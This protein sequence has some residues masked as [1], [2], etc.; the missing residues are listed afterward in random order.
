MSPGRIASSNR[1]P[2]ADGRED[3]V[4]HR[5]A[6]AL[7]DALE[8]VEVEDEDRHPRQAV[9]ALPRERVRGPVQEERAV[10]QARER[11]VE[12]LT[13]E[14]LLDRPAL[15]DVADRRGACRHLV[16]VGD[17]PPDQLHRGVR[18]IGQK[19]RCLDRHLGI[20]LEAA[21]DRLALRLREEP[22]DREAGHGGRR[23]PE[24]VDERAVH[25]EDAPIA[26][27]DE[28]LERRVRQ[29]AEALG[30]RPQLLLGPLARR[31]LR[32][33]GCVEP[34]VLEGHRRELG[35]AADR[36]DVVGAE[37]APLLP[38]SHADDAHDLAPGRERNADRR[39]DRLALESNRV[40]RPRGVV[41][42]DER[43]ARFPDAAGE[44][45]A[46]RELEAVPAREDPEP[47]SDPQHVGRRIDDVEVAVRRPDESGRASDDRLEQLVG[48]A[49]SEQR[50]RG[51]VERREVLGAVPRAGHP[52]GVPRLP[53]GCLLQV[54]LRVGAHDELVARA[55]VLREGRDAHADG[56]ARTRSPRPERLDLRLQAIRHGARLGPP[57]PRQ[58]RGELVAAVPVDA[59][60]RLDAD[61]GGER[62]RHRHEEPVAGRMAEAVVED[63]EPVEV[64]HEQGERP[65]E[66]R[67]AGAL[68][69][70]GQVG[71]ERPVVQRAGERVA[72]RAQL[73]RMS[74]L[75]G[76]DRD[77]G[78]AGEERDELDLVGAE[79]HRIRSR[80]AHVERPDHVA[81]GAERDDDERLGLVRR[82]RDER[83]AR[84][85]VRLVRHDDF[86]VR[87]R[88][89]REA[90][91]QRLLVGEDLVR[92]HVARKHG[93][94]CAALPVESV[95]REA[96][97][98][99]DRSERVGDPLEHGRGVPCRE[100]C[101]VDLEEHALACEP[102]LQLILLGTQLTDVARVD[103][104]LRGEPTEDREGREVV[105]RVAVHALLRDDDDA[106]DR[107]AVRHR[108]DQ[109]RLR[110]VGADD[111]RPRLAPCVADAERRVVLG[112]PAREAGPHGD[113]QERRVGVLGPEE[114]AR[115][116]DRLAHARL[117]VDRVH[118]GAV[119]VVQLADLGDDRA[120]DLVDVVDVVQL[121]RE[122]LDR[123][124]ARGEPFD[125]RVETGVLERDRGLRG[126]GLEQ[127]DLVLHPPPP[128]AVVEA[129]H[130]DRIV[131]V[132]D[133]HE[134]GRPDPLGPVHGPHLRRGPPDGRPVEDD[135]ALG[136][137]RADRA[138]P[139]RRP[140]ALHRAEESFAQAPVGD[141]AVGVVSRLDRPD[142]HLVRPE[143]RDREIDDLAEDAREVRLAA[144][145]GRELPEGGVTAGGGPRAAGTVR[146]FGSFRPAGTVPDG[147]VFCG[148][149]G[150]TLGRWSV[151]PS[152]RSRGR[153][154]G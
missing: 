26:M 78:L 3:L 95:D 53:A 22:Q 143:E 131:E 135:R 62:V 130:A 90:H 13:R 99:D 71:L 107:P 119:R 79:L 10:R 41:V 97:V 122:V 25:L 34:R 40:A 8:P 32:P 15:A 73:G 116:R 124:E 55:A 144:D 148:S 35:E 27:D 81:L 93:H 87:D 76:L 31:D 114:D 14:A 153:R 84:I 133:R 72:L 38:A 46:A 4:A 54:E 128:R 42:D 127:V 91:V 6:E 125:A 29:A 98:L 139:A 11:V 33:G 100:Q 2:T 141:E 65:G 70:R 75:D 154:F 16:G 21:L 112:D 43:F 113:P 63:L 59:V 151:P 85:E 104:R 105:R 126:E 1:R 89:A 44:P 17:R 109:H 5:V 50:V 7:V 30:A 24:Q 20:H 108:R 49:A 123:A 19:D 52:D 68:E 110:L 134:A 69:E 83:R 115:E 67:P 88:P 121:A 9:L 80:S 51:L 58:E 47:H 18:P 136:V 118:P 39:S 102:A 37:R 140:E 103:Q 66:G 149:H 12:R 86:A 82:A 36:R 64:E 137:H 145:F 150:F 120:A 146:A 101:L 96:V 147:I 60:A 111:A 129:D 77:R 132:D 45:L 74:R 138:G 94:P 57:E 142:P 106:E 117:V 28:G 48:V 56:H 92:V 61:R 23:S 152:R